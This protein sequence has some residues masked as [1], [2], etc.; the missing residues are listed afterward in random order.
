MRVRSR[1]IALVAM[2]VLLASLLGPSPALADMAPLPPDDYVPV[3]DTVSDENGDASHNSWVVDTDDSA[4]E[5]NTEHDDPQDVG[6]DSESHRPAW[7]PFILLGLG[8][9]LLSIGSLVIIIRLSKR[10]LT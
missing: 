7:F 5:T 4:Q 8:V 10:S 6:R 1:T 9:L 3:T 2:I